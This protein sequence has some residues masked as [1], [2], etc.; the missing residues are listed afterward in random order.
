MQFNQ[1]WLKKHSSNH[2]IIIKNTSDHI[3]RLNISF[4]KE[5]IKQFLLSTRF[6]FQRLDRVQ[7][8]SKNAN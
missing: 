1:I 2:F 6:L 7:F 5:G 3:E 8:F 4:D